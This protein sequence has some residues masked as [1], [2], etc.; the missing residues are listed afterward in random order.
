MAR[1]MVIFGGR[2]G[3]HE[4]SLASA[5]AVMEALESGGRHEVLPVGI[6]REGRWLLSGD[7]MRALTDGNAG[8]GGE[9]SSAVGSSLPG[10]LGPADVVFPVMHGPYG[11]DGK[12]QGLLEMAGIPYVGSGVLG[13]AV[14]MDK[15][16]MKKVFAHHGLPQV[17]WRGLV[18]R[19]WEQDRE[20]VIRAVESEP[21]YPCFVKPS[22][23][24][25]SVGINRAD[26][27][28][29][30][31]AALDEAFRYDRRVIVEQF[32][33]AREVEVSVLGND[34]PEV[35]LPGE[36]VLSGG[37]FYDYEAK[38]GEGG[39]RLVVPAE[40]P[41][42][43]AGEIERIA[44][45]AF[46]AVDAAGMSRIDFFLER[47]TGKLFLNEINTIPGFT[48]TSVYAKLWEASGLPYPDLLD[49]LISLAL[50][51][52]AENG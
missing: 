20:A 22:N 24:G 33:D 45:E 26:D 49:R 19:D 13:S 16:T 34:H 15:V 6:T 32:V 35:S 41:E 39:M 10:T 47:S 14:G 4:V 11:E 44:R 21:G 31:A 43:A 1:V 8:P 25:S 46:T 36:V 3:E 51:R 38:Y 37:A 2:S 12:M 28:E 18:R 52:H 17:R 29:G 23:L 48:A 42:E 30:L 7:P 50:E 5:R 40:I 27:E 9:L